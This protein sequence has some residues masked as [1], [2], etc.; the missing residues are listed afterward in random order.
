MAKPGQAL[1]PLLHEV[2]GHMA[3]TGDSYLNKIAD[4]KG[5]IREL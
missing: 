5:C 1:L 3:I 2:V 4:N